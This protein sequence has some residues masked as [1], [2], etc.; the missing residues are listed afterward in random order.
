MIVS[1]D[2]EAAVLMTVSSNYHARLW[3]KNV[4][5]LRHVTVI[6][7]RGLAT[8]SSLYY[9]V[10][11]FFIIVSFSLLSFP[12]W[13]SQKTFKCAPWASLR[14]A[15]YFVSFAAA[16]V[17]RWRWYVESKDSTIFALLPLFSYT[18]SSSIVLPSGFSLNVV[19]SRGQLSGCKK[20]KNLSCSTSASTAASYIFDNQNDVWIC[21]ISSYVNRVFSTERESGPFLQTSTFQIEMKILLKRYILLKIFY[22]RVNLPAP[23]LVPLFAIPFY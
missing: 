6:I 1:N 8:N 16:T 18:R 22:T 19:I 2:E 7:C 15:S 20:L 21:F 9:I 4:V 11:F 23:R 12:E 13:F 17:G 10:V 14:K 5:I 3:Q